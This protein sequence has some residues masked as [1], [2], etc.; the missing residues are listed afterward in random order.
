MDKK[1]VAVEK[2]MYKVEGGRVYIESAELANAIQ[3]EG[4]D[5]FVDEEANGWGFGCNNGCDVQ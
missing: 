4:L 5:L 2:E 1:V 3:N